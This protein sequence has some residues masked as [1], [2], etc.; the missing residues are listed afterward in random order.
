MSIQNNT[1]ITPGG[2]GGAD[3]VSHR[4]RSGA[5]S[6]PVGKA[7]NRSVSQVTTGSPQTALGSPPPDKK[8][9]TRSASA[10]ATISAGPQALLTSEKFLSEIGL[11]L[12]KKQGPTLQAV[13]AGLEKFHNAAGADAKARL[14]TLGELKD[15]ATTYLHKKEAELAKHPKDKALIDRVEGTRLLLQ[16]I[17]AEA[18]AQ[19]KGASLELL[20]GGD[21]RPLATELAKLPVDIIAGSLGEM[22]QDTRIKVMGP[23]LEALR[24]VH[25]DNLKSLDLVIAVIEQPGVDASAHHLDLAM[26]I[27][28]GLPEENAKTAVYA[29]QRGY[30]DVGSLTGLAQ[31]NSQTL[32]GLEMQT[33]DGAQEIIDTL[34]TQNL[35]GT[36]AWE[37]VQ[38]NGV[39]GS[40]DKEQS[41]DFK[42]IITLQANTVTIDALKKEG[43]GDTSLNLMIHTWDSFIGS[44]MESYAKDIPKEKGAKVMDV[45]NDLFNAQLDKLD[46]SYFQGVASGHAVDAR[47]MGWEKLPD[48][49]RTNPDISPTGEQVVSDF[50]ARNAPGVASSLIRARG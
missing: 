44:T 36:E 38:K 8:I 31:N 3:G 18:A 48:D 42:K 30:L 41:P 15:N 27:A 39:W 10:P 33:S 2:P 40:A 4:G 32:G 28:H 9:L 35:E 22:A 50:F 34:D 19:V 25:K 45:S 12:S 13:T 21:Q 16:S 49:W 20:K 23:V 11:T 7:F 46:S 26:V 24:E 37:S 14:E 5:V 29:H 43:G 6:R 1:P 17:N 47:A